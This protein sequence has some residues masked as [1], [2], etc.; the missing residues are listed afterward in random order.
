MNYMKYIDDTQKQ[1]TGYNF[2]QYFNIGLI[3]LISFI[4]G[5]IAG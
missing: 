2:N 4:A 3:V 5:I 1:F